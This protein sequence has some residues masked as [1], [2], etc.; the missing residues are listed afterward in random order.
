MSNV[1]GDS[2]IRRLRKEKDLTIAELADG[3]C[4]EEHLT[5]IERGGRVPSRWV[6]KMLMERLGENPNKYYTDVVTLEDKRVVNEKD[7]LKNL[8]RECTSEAN[9]KAEE[10]ISKLESDKAFETKEN[11]QFLL[12]YKAALAYNRENYVDLYNLAIEAM[13]VTKT[14]FDVDK[15]ETY[16]LSSDEI[17]LVNQIGI[18]YFYT[19]TVEK[20]ANVFRKLRVVIEK[21]CVE[22]DAM[23]HTYAALMYNLSKNLG[24]LGE[25]N[26][27]LEVCVKGIEWCI[28]HRESHH[29]PMI[30]F[31]KS[32]CMLHLNDRDGG[33]ALL[34]QVYAFLKGLGRDG[35]LHQI[36]GYVA[37]QFQ[38]SIDNLNI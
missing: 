28:E 36:K 1:L 7:K 16:F 34:K 6:F 2:L 14:D 17:W 20:S 30:M 3:I 4:S 19:E 9:K 31:H 23:I 13:A 29:H 8:L 27:C 33:T 32:C 21:G 37:H 18:A 24:I 11:W 35:E 12:M 25:F 15:I 26:E 10:L 38:I 5:R 22:G